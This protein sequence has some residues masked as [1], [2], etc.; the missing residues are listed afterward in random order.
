MNTVA[1]GKI[2]APVG[3]KGEMRVFSYTDELTRFSDVRE[4]LID[5]KRYALASVRY[6]K[7]M[8]VISLSGISDRSMA[9]TMRGKTLEIPREELWEMPEDTYLVDDLRGLAVISESGERIGTLAEV[10]SRS[11]Q[12]LYRIEKTG[13]GDF[14]LPAVK[15]FVRSVDTES[16]TIT[17]RLIEGIADL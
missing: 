14:L 17:V 4:V 5:G 16:G 1:I 8:A 12:D 6:Q 15:E 9:E 7:G 10:I 11:A 3:I 2:T 13:G